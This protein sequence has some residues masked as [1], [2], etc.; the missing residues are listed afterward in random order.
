[1]IK[2]RLYSRSWKT[3]FP[4]PSQSS[5]Q[6]LNRS[7]RVERVSISSGERSSPSSEVQLPSIREGVTDLGMTDVPRER[8][9]TSR[10]A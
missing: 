1:M 9:Q 6:T 3:L 8:P 4:G 2:Q 5:P 10:T 7:G